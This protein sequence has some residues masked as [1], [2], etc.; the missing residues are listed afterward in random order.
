MDEQVNESALCQCW[1]W[2]DWVLRPFLS[3]QGRR[4]SV[5]EGM[6]LRLAVSLTTP[7]DLTLAAPFPSRFHHLLGWLNEVIYVKRVVSDT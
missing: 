6:E 4:Y 3:V 2:V 7:C 5:G 1:G